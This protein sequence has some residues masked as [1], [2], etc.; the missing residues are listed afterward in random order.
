MAAAIIN[1]VGFISGVL[2]TAGFAQTNLP[3]SPP[4]GARVRVKV[5]LES[6]SDQQFVRT[7]L[8]TL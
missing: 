8:S 5:G 7:P 4:S 3:Q 2:T 1:A 6:N